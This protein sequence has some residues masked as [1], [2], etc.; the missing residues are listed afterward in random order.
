MD[1]LTPNQLRQRYA[2]SASLL[3]R[4]LRV[5]PLGSQTFSK[6]HTQYPEG[7]SPLFVTRGDGGRVWDV[8]GNE[9]VDLVSALLPVVLGYRDPDVDGAI[10]DQLDRGISFSLGTELE[11]ELAERLTRIIPCAEMV[12]FAKNGSD[13]TSAA[14]RVARAHTGRDR[15]AVC[16]YHGWHD[17]YIGATV[18]KRGI[19]DCVGALTTR[20]AFNDIDSLKALL[21]AHPGEYAAV[22]METVGVEEPRP[23]FLEEVRDLIHAHGGVLIFDEVITG[24]R[25]ALGGAQARYG[26]TPD[27]ASFGKAMANGMPLSAVVGR[28][29]LMH[30]MEE[31]FFSAT[32]G[33]EALSLAAAIATIDKMEREPVIDRLWNTGGRIKRA[34]ATKITEYGLDGVISVSGIDP[35][36]LHGFH[37]HANARKEAVRTLFTREMLA[38]GVLQNGSINV[39]YAH[40]DADVTHVLAAYDGALAT[41]AEEI[42]R[43]GVEE[44]LGCPVLFPVFAVRGR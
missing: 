33:G 43:P 12:R 28:A 35:W 32:F 31:I 23:G 4:A 20:F 26:V 19:P 5:I 16:G 7:Q 10:R 29:D 37:D 14:V 9:Y 3:E 36:G 38:R 2:A 17:W 13:A 42:A 15:I 24:F 34:V 1:K 6:S 25:V 18:R 27:L 40:D 8:D 44:R 21:D 22:I 30:E 39:C 11:V 41:V